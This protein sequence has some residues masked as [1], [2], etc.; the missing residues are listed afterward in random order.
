MAI[1]K[2]L[3]ERKGDALHAAEGFAE[4]HKGTVKPN[5]RVD[6]HTVFDYEDDASLFVWGEAP[7]FAVVGGDEEG[8]F[9]YLWD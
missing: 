2:A 3:Y 4:E 6:S 8:I 7:A 9:A 1:M 5:A